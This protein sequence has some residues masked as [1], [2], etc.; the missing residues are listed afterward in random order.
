M[1]NNMEDLSLVK[2]TFPKNGVHAYS[3]IK[4]AKKKRK[5]KESDIYAKEALSFHI[6]RASMIMLLKR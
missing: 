1:E 4:K 5:F 3:L 2:P 6:P